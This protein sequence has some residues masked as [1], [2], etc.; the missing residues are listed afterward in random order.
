MKK[1]NLVAISAMIGLSVL[2]T[3]SSIAMSLYGPKNKRDPGADAEGFSIKLPRHFEITKSGV[4]PFLIERIP[5]KLQT[6]TDANTLL[7]HVQA[8]GWN[9]RMLVVK[10]K[11]DHNYDFRKS[12]INGEGYAL[13]DLKTG[14]HS[15]YR[16][17][18]RMQKKHPQ[19]HQIQV[20]PLDRYHWRTSAQSQKTKDDPVITSRVFTNMV[21]S[22]D[23]YQ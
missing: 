11:E 9:R 16:T 15:W 18:K 2:L 23:H 19:M 17:L 7:Y 12:G 5:R 6:T 3:V 21:T 20:K 10:S 4:G 8:V 22:S 14:E 13:I 1:R